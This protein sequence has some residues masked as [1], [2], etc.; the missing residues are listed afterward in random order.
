MKTVT[1]KVEDYLYEFYRLI[2]E[3]AGGLSPEQVM[4]DSLFKLA[5]ALSSTVTKEKVSTPTFKTPKN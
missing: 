3:D 4:A 2:G 1:I 5:G